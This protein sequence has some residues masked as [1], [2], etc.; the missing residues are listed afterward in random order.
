MVKYKL[1]FLFILILLIIT[2]GA[3]CISFSSQSQ[4]VKGMFRSDDQGENWKAISAY[5]TVQGVKNISGVNTY[6]VVRD[7]SDDNALYLGSRGQGLYYSYNNGD[8]WNMVPYFNNRFIYS[9]AIDPKNK[10]NIYVT[11][12]SHI[13]NSIDCNRTWV[14]SYTEERISSRLSDLAIDF[15]NSKLIYASQVNGDILRSQDGGKSWLVVKRFGFGVRNIVVDPNIKNRVYVASH[16]KGFY[17]SDDAGVTW[18]N[19]SDDFSNYSQ[20]NSYY[21]L[22]INPQKKGSLYWVSKYGILH[23]ADY[24]ENWTD[25]KLLTSPGSVNIYAFAVNPKNQK[26]IY[27]IGTVLSDKGKNVRST[28]YRSSDGGNNWVTRKLPTNTIPVYLSVH[29]KNDKVIFSG[30]SALD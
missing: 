23:S 7:P 26:E 13:Y 11:D 22:I 12:G 25:I 29:P 14:L 2:T 5:P 20:S 21:R 9:I 18:K 24:G 30:F 6:V 4:G 15:N 10:C 8:S 28:F 3:G 27:Y 16:N 17:R 1:S 19:L